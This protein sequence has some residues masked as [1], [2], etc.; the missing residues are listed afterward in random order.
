MDY[1]QENENSFQ[2]YFTWRVEPFK[3]YPSSNTKY[4]V[5]LSSCYFCKELKRLTDQQ[6]KAMSIN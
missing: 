4:Y 5:V 1:H 3:A 2:N 6:E